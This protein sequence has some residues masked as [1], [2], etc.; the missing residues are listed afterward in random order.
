MNLSKIIFALL[1][2]ISTSSFAQSFNFSK[3]AEMTYSH[4]L[5]F[6]DFDND[7]IDDIL[8]YNNPEIILFKGSESEDLD[9][10]FKRSISTVIPFPNL[11]FELMNFELGDFD[12]DGDIDIF[13]Q[14]WGPNW[15]LVKNDET[16]FTIKS[17]GEL[18]Y[19]NP[20][21]WSGD[22]NNDG[23]S[24]IYI[25]FESS[26]LNDSIS[27]LEFENDNIASN[28]GIFGSDIYSDYQLA[29][30]NADNALEIFGIDKDNEVMNVIFLDSIEISTIHTIDNIKDAYNLDVANNLLD[31]DGNGTLDLIYHDNGFSQGN[32]LYCIYDI[33]S[34]DNQETTI[35][36]SFERSISTLFFDIDTDGDLEVIIEVSGEFFLYNSDGINISATPIKFNETFDYVDVLHLETNLETKKQLYTIDASNKIVL[37]EITVNS[38]TSVSYDVLTDFNS[39]SPGEVNRVIVT[40]VNLDG[41]DDLL[42]HSNGSGIEVAVMYNNGDGSYSE[43][44]VIIDHIIFPRYV[45]FEDFNNDDI[46]DIAFYSIRTGDFV[47]LQNINGKFTEVYRY[48]GDHHYVFYVSDFNQ[49][50]FKDLVIMQSSD[51]PDYDY[52]LEGLKNNNGENFEFVEFDNSDTDFLFN[53]ADFDNDGSTE[54]VHR[55]YNSEKVTIGHI[56]D[57][58][59]QV[60]EQTSIGPFRESKHFDLDDDGDLEFIAVNVDF[61]A[62]VF[63]IQIYDYN[64][65]SIQFDLVAKTN[66]FS[67]SNS[68]TIPE[69]FIYFD[70]NNDGYDDLITYKNNSSGFEGPVNLYE[71]NGTTLEYRGELINYIDFDNTLNLRDYIYL[72]TKDGINR[73]LVLADGAYYILNGDDYANVTLCTFLDENENDQKDGNESYVSSTELKF[74]DGQNNTYSYITNES[75][76]TTAQLNEDTYYL[77]LNPISCLNDNVNDSIEIE[78]NTQYEF[79]LVINNEEGEVSAD[80]TRA[81]TRCSFNSTYWIQVFN[82]TC[83]NFSGT[84]DVFIEENSTDIVPILGGELIEPNTL[85]YVIEE[86][87]IGG[88]MKFEANIKMPNADF[89]DEDLEDSY[90]LV[91]MNGDEISSETLKYHLHCEFDPN[92]KSISPDRTAGYGEQYILDEDLEYLIRFENV[93]IDSAINIKVLDRISDNLDLE[94]IDIISASHPYRYTLNKVT[95]LLTVYFDDIYLPDNKTDEPG[96]HG[97]FK[98]KIRPIE[99]LPNFIDIDNEALIYFDFNPPIYTNKTQSTYIS[100]LSLVSTTY[101][102]DEVAI[103]IFP[104]PTKDLLTI[105]SDNSEKINAIHIFTI[106]GEYVGEIKSNNGQLNISHL[107]SGIY[108]IKVSTNAQASVHKMIKI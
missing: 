84:L 51:D 77:E 21:I 1:L 96:S 61:Q 67:F 92:N 5:L 107:R 33:E 95:R 46:I 27:I 99:G 82:N 65:S 36:D 85:R 88:K 58:E 105:R 55:S 30:I 23:K 108:L 49:D 94:T 56:I 35:I 52:K 18:G 41:F 2:C 80:I 70:Y 68:S 12:G 29:D 44:E 25:K 4:E 86:L 93:G 20:E 73:Y 63:N 101:T 87:P 103:K 7:G 62:D 59:L 9:K 15:F 78:L 22:Y 43:R 100:D 64:S 32:Y 98:F 16:K 3:I 39:S 97:F 69:D 37:A 71:Y 54:F 81:H 104:N 17:L 79:P 24:D 31:F 11:F 34:I 57:N 74:T 45:H 89:L 60:V 6:A 47:I 53:V 72:D 90:L 38:D 13:Y 42:Y 48:D 14:E 83:S 50:G 91:D 75:G 19:D 106:N 76:C 10:K 40:D 26:G 66:D 102:S 28:I 8:M